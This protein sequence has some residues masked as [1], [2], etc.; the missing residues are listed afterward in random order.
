MYTSQKPL[1]QYFCPKYTKC[2]YGWA[3]QS[4]SLLRFSR[5]V[6][7][8]LNFGRS[9][10]SISQQHLITCLKVGS[11]LF[12]WPTLATFSKLS[13]VT[14]NSGM[15]SGSP[16]LRISALHPLFMVVWYFLQIISLLLQIHVSVF[17]HSLTCIPF[18][19]V[20]CNLRYLSLAGSKGSPLK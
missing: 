2:I 12:C 4:N 16:H 10:G 13:L 9:I 11:V 6:T 20:P 8:L 5:L 17:N 19:S 7:N 3:S 1:S 14:L 15:L 18:S